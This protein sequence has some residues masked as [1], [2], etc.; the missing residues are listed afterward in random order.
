[1]TSVK[2]FAAALLCACLC[3]LSLPAGLR[4]EAVTSKPSRIINLVYDD[5]TSM[6]RDD[7]NTYL[8]RWCQAKYALEVFASMLS[9]NDTMNVYVMSDF[10]YG[11]AGPFLSLSGSTPPADNVK[12]VHD[13][14]TNLSAT[15]I[16]AV[17]KARDDVNNASADQKWLVVLTDG[18]FSRDV[19]K[20]D[21]LS[22]SDL[23]G[24]LRKKNDDVSVAFLSIGKDAATLP[25]SPAE[26]I[27]SYRAENSTDILGQLTDMSN[28]IF[29]LN[30]LTV[31]GSD[32][33]LSFDI[34]MNQL[35]VFAQGKG[36]S[37]RGIEMPSGQTMQTGQSTVNVRYSEVAGENYRND[38]KI[39]VNTN[40]EGEIASFEGDFDPG[41]YQV[42]VS[43][44][45]TVE[46]Y[47]RPNIEIAAYLK[48][49]DGNVV[50]SG[51][52]IENG[53]YTLDLGFVK[54]GTSDP[55]PQS[56]LLGNVKFSAEVSQNGIPDGKTYSSGDTVT[57]GEGQLSVDATA[58]YL[59]Y[60][61]ITTHLEFGVFSN[62]LVTFKV[63]ES[64]VNVVTPKGLTDGGP[65]AV[66]ATLDGEEIP[67][68]VWEQ[69]ELPSVEAD[70][71]KKC[72]VESVKIKKGREPGLFY[73]TAELKDGKPGTV[74]YEPAY[75]GL[76]KYSQ[77]IG[78][79]TWSG[80]TGLNFKF[81]DTREWYELD[82]MMIPKLI[83]LAALLLIILGYLFK[84]KLP[85]SM[86]KRPR[87][88]CIP[89]MIG[90]SR[91]TDTG[92]VDKVLISYL[93]PF[94]A[95]RAKVEFAPVGTVAMPKLCL[96]AAGGRRMTVSNTHDYSEL[97]E[98]MLNGKPVQ[99]CDANAKYSSGLNISVKSDGWEYLC[100][101][102]K[103]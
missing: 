70:F 88:E 93:L 65:V 35:I 44:A 79:E 77:K 13:M 87:I 5:S 18:E 84:K 100:I 58:E 27:F 64:P 95:Q 20:G 16:Q 36:V 55:V 103:E 4:T 90:V 53:D 85:R 49:K 14:I 15:P 73:I 62:K 42:D 80:G 102:N 41:D 46:V 9:E 67:Q 29:E 76:L 97:D 82:P 19:F 39:V 32:G 68:D 8:D 31:D 45:S 69:M 10:C 30:R 78:N 66:R 23:Q 74:R 60:N 17:E 28:R 61:T 6:I 26:N 94:V 21:T 24:V 11:S 7:A 50:V 51:D 2:K 43:G 72:N 59:E 54:T 37:I 99:N 34:P 89:D 47:Y 91:E 52:E 63:E 57:V 81:D 3:F 98:M 75:Q 33:K 96:K 40:L 25:D 22:T 38:P 71:P 86:K 12:A 83:A 92:S 56:S 48:D 1:M 101:L